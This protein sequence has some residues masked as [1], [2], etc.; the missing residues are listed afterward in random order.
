MRHAYP[1]ARDVVAIATDVLLVA[2]ALTLAI[3]RPGG[4]FAL[5]L[6]IGVPCVLGW[7]W[8]TLHFPRAVEIDEHGVSFE[9]FRRV[10]R[11]EWSSVRAVRVRRF[12]TGDR[13]LVRV[14][15]A[16]PLRGRYWILDAIGGYRELVATLEK[17][18][19]G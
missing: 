12:L 10:H 17:H 19:Q 7:Q 9:G 11:Y 6:G 5:A 4:T 16:P 3:T 18:A 2:V 1:R 14:I 15:P 8:L 13:V